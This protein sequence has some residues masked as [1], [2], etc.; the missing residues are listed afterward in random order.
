M[1]LTYIAWLPDLPF[2]ILSAASSASQGTLVDITERR[3]I[4]KRLHQ[5][6]EFVRHLMAS[7]PD[8][9]A[10]FDRER[11]LHLRQS[12]RE[13]GSRRSAARNSLGSRIELPSAPE[14]TPKES[15]RYFSS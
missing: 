8:M 7:F 14:K 11:L 10:V 5:E 13:G 9:I 2:A 12:A 15:T 3:E 1:V 6:Q 4:E